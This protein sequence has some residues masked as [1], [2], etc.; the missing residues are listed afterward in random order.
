MLSA[1]S[2]NAIRAWLASAAPCLVAS[3][4]DPLPSARETCAVNWEYTSAE[5]ASWHAA[6]TGHSGHNFDFFAPLLD[7][8]YHAYGAF[9][10]GLGVRQ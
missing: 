5:L 3:L 6:T 1:A 4:E 10:L 8:V 2:F 7:R 9:G